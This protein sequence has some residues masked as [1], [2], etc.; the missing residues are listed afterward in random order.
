MINFSEY[1]DIADSVFNSLGISD[2]IYLS[3]D[4]NS[5]REFAKQ[6]IYDTD[7]VDALV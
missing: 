3:W 6:Y 2:D 5:M 7:Y 4:R 1:R